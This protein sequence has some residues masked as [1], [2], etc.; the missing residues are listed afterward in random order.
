M[1]ADASN[2]PNPH[3]AQR[4][5]YAAYWQKKLKGAD[6]IQFPD[7]LIDEFASKTDRFSFAY[8]KEAFVSTLLAIAGNDGKHDAHFPE[9][10]L[11]EVKC[12]RK[13]IDDG[14]EKLASEP[15]EAH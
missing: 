12:L 15:A 11:K 1:T 14:D 4:R 13:E 10:L 2:F 8:M 7:A 6:G 9:R 3:R 5:Q